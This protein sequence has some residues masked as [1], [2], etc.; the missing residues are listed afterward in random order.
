EMNRLGMVIDVSHLSPAGFW[1][2]LEASA[3]PV[4]ASHSNSQALCGHRRN[5]TDC[6][7][8][9][10]AEQGGVIG[11]TFAPQFLRD[12]PEGVSLDQFRRWAGSSTSLA[13]VLDH[14]DHFVGLVGPEHV[15]LG[16]DF[17]GI[18]AVP[19][20]LEDVSRLP[21]LTRG[22]LERG[23][24]EEAVRGILGENLRRLFETVWSRAEAAP[25]RLTA[26]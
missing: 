8:K 23:Y 10:L 21:A 11:V 9:A 1:Q 2:V 3:A 7:A 18:D 5:L 16:S 20:G 15:A 26:P 22:L 24:P 19:A 17:D 6:Q 14:L 25:E 13:D 12:A 4:V